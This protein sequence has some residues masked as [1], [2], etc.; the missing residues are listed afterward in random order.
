MSI[1]EIYSPV[2]HTQLYT[3]DETIFKFVD[4]NIT[5]WQVG[6]RL[7]LNNSISYARNVA[8]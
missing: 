7:L 5:C 1:L 8:N 4:V 6:R 3:G 2:S